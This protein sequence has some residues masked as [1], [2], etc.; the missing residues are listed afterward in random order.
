MT[1]EAEIKARFWKELK[2]ERT[3]MIGA[4]RRAGRRHAADDR[5]GR[6]G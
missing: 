1:N 6:G 2:S 4:R 5:L 3:I